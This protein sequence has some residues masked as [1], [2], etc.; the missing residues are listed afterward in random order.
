MPSLDV[1]SKINFAELDNAINNTKK[2]VA[3]RFDFRNSPIELTVNQ[4]DKKLNMH[5]A[6][7]GK[8]KALQEMFTQAAV[9]RGLDVRCFEWE[10]IEGARHAALGN[11]KREVKL[12]DGL[13]PELAKQISKL[14]KESGIKVQASI[15][16]DEVRLTGKQIDDLRACMDLITKAGLSQPV[17]FVNMKS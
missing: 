10:D 2:A 14:V 15:Q 9:K 6:D 4:K 13:P 17:Q 7:E 3:T 8:M 5:A 12:R 16:G 11:C 1:V